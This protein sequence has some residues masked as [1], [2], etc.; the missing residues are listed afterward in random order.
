MKVIRLTY[1]TRL[2]LAMSAYLGLYVLGENMAW[3][4]R[5]PRPGRLGAAIELVRGWSR[6]LHLHEGVR[7]A[8]CLIIPYVVLSRGWVSPLDLGLADLDWIRG[9]GRAV[10]ITAG[11]LILLAFT[12]WQY[13]RLLGSEA[14][15]PHVDWL[16]Q[17]WGWAFA[18]REAIYLEASWALVRSPMLLLAGPYFG[19]YL[20]LAAVYAAELLSARVRHELSIPGIREEAVLTASLAVVTATLFVYVH[21]LW[22]CIAAHASLRLAVARLVQWRVGRIVPQGPDSPA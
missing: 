1:A 11:S 17:P 16:A 15:V 20:G 21:N 18:V 13:A 7:L 22:L 8:Y 19:A 6:R 9:S 5:D 3:A 10:A 2:L 14:A 4:W 12:W